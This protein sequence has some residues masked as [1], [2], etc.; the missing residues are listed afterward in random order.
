MKQDNPSPAAHLVRFGVATSRGAYRTFLR[1][2]WMETDLAQDPARA[3]S[4]TLVFEKALERPETQFPLGTQPWTGVL[5]RALRRVARLFADEG[6][7]TRFGGTKSGAP[8]A[9]VLNA[10]GPLCADMDS[11]LEASGFE[12]QLGESESALRSRLAAHLPSAPVLPDLG[13]PRMWL[14]DLFAGMMHAAMWREIVAEP[15]TLRLAAAAAADFIAGVIKEIDS[16]GSS[17]TAAMM[18]QAILVFAPKAVEYGLGQLAWMTTPESATE[19]EEKALPYLRA[20][21]SRETPLAPIIASVVV[22]PVP[23]LGKTSP[24][25]AEVPVL[26]AIPKTG[27]P[28]PNL[29]PMFTP[30]DDDDEM[31][32]PSASKVRWFIGAI[33]IVLVIATLI[34]IFGDGGIDTGP[35][36]PNVNSAVT[37]VNEAAVK[38]PEKMV[39]SPIAPLPEPEQVA[40][41]PAGVMRLFEQAQFFIEAAARAKRSGDNRQAAEDLSRALLIFKQEF[42]EQRWNDERYLQLRANYRVQLGLL[43]LTAEQVSAIENIMGGREP[44]TASPEEKTDFVKV[45]TIFK[46]GDEELARGRPKAAAEAYELALRTG[47]SILGDKSA[48]DR[49]YQQ[50]LS[51]YID[52]LI[53][54]NLEDNE[55]QLRIALVRA[56]KKP[57]PLPDKKV[58]PE[59]EGLGL[60]KL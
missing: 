57:K 9:P 44:T 32:P 54:E 13:A 17:P 42:G 19:L 48:N 20:A 7:A 16:D 18:E 6:L 43:E 38:G 8:I 41:A 37:P 3:E 40:A 39:V 47:L 25:A 23:M 58:Q 10:F 14:P 5:A 21:F 24:S 46:R 29:G 51:S 1:H 52:F 12:I 11:E 36:L 22:P 59:A 31:P 28:G 30:D 26:R 2:V 56:G 27:D 33:G 45:A 15:S 49:T 4:A 53:S 60:P 50:Y 34:S 55:M 35:T